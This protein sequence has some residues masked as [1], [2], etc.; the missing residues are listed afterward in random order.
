MFSPLWSSVVCGIKDWVANSLGMLRS[1]CPSG[2]HQH[3]ANEPQPQPVNSVFVD[4]PCFLRVVD[5][6]LFACVRCVGYSCNKTPSGSGFETAGLKSLGRQKRHVEDLLFSTHR[7]LRPCQRVGSAREPRTTSPQ[8]DRGD[9]RT[10]KTLFWSWLHF[11]S[12]LAP[13]WLLFGSFWLFLALSGSILALSVF[14]LHFGSVLAPFWLHF[15]SILA[16]FWLRF[17]SVLAPA[18]FWLFSGSVLAPFWLLFGSGQSQ[19]KPPPPPADL[20]WKRFP[21]PCPCS[22]AWPDRCAPGS[23]RR[24]TIPP[25]NLADGPVTCCLTPPN[26]LAKFLKTPGLSTA[27]QTCLEWVGQTFVSCFAGDSIHFYGGFSQSPTLH[28]KAPLDEGPE[29]TAYVVAKEGGVPH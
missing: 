1:Y 29:N 9:P 10:G 23:L 4:G 2:L 25:P 17:G 6:E 16:P 28:W 27:G 8:S 3:T 12:V 20:P 19:A 11:G 18:P 24:V 14:W 13:F 7:R 15:G 5:P 21:V 26:L 22:R